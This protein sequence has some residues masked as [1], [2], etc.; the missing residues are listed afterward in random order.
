MADNNIIERMLAIN[1][2]LETGNITEKSRHQSQPSAKTQEQLD[3]LI[4]EWDNVAYGKSSVQE[5]TPVYSAEAEMERLKE[6]E[7]NGGRG[8]VNLEGRRI[9]SAIVEEIINNPLDLKP[10][11]SDP[12]MDALENRLTAK[13]PGGIKASL[14]VLEKM[15]KAEKENRETINE[16]AHSAPVQNVTVDY[17]LIKSIVENVVEEKMSSIKQSLNETIAHESKQTYVPSTKIMSFK[18]N[19]YFVDNDDNVFECVMKYKGKNKKHK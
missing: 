19:F 9:P 16:S 8:A 14:N 12:N 7:K 3:R 4:N 11:F 5:T 17:G 6:I 2:Q 15:E 1:K 18:D 13:M 10:D